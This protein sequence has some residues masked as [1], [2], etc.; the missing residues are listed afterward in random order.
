MLAIGR[1][2]FQVDVHSCDAPNQYSHVVDVCECARY[3]E[4][5]GK[6][7]IC[8][9]QTPMPEHPIEYTSVIGDSCST[10]RRHIQRLIGNIAD[11][12]VP[13]GWDE[14]EEHD[15]EEHDIIVATYWSIVFGVGYHSWVV[16]T[17]NG[18]VLLSSGGPY[19]GEQLL[20]TS[21]ISELGGTVIG[22]A[23]IDTPVRSGKIKVESVKFVCDNEA[24]IKACKR[25]AH[26]VFSTEHREDHL[27]RGL[28]DQRWV[29][30]VTQ[31]EL[32]T[33]Y[34]WRL[35]IHGHDYGQTFNHNKKCSQFQA[36]L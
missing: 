10:L 23:V 16:S 5:L 36:F 25:K 34:F 20:M 8:E 31:P 27:R 7:K 35:V 29:S 4:I 6:H 19:D 33:W 3:M 15:D 26:K 22:L 24:V 28:S 2:R 9:T 30:P 32:Y 21:Y 11:T 1:L 17:N 18:H 12:D 13:S 14:D